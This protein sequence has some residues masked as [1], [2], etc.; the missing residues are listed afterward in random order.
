MDEFSEKYYFA[1]W[2]RILCIAIISMIAF[3]IVKIVHQNGHLSFILSLCLLLITLTAILIANLSV[4]V[5]PEK[6]SIR[7]FP[8]HLKEIHYQK[9]DITT[10][11]VVE[12][13]PISKFGGWGIRYNL[14]K[15][16]I[17]STSGRNAIYLVVKG[18]VRYIGIHKT[19]QLIK[20]LNLHYTGLYKA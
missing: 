9:E 2:V 16:K 10:I 6:I 18:K 19:T 17:F 3:G 1:K 14:D 13:N 8:S 15:E 12:Y 11:K 20:L 5:S 4:K 7:F